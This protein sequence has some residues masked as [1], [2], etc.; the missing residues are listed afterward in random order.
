MSRRVPK[1]PIVKKETMGV[2]SVEDMS[3]SELKELLWTEREASAKL[4][5]IVR[6]ERETSAVLVAKLESKVEALKLER[7]DTKNM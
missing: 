5:S 4:V 3:I 6:A 1:Q 2:K 7:K